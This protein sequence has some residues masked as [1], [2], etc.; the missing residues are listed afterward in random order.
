MKKNNLIKITWLLAIC[1]FILISCGKNEP[2]NTG[3][4]ENKNASGKII[5][6]KASFDFSSTHEKGHP[7]WYAG[8]YTDDNGKSVY[9][10]TEGI[11]C[12]IDNSFK[13][14]NTVEYKKH[15]YN[16]LNEIL[17]EIENKYNTEK[18]AE[19]VKGGNI[20]II[21]NAVEIYLYEESTQFDKI[22][23]ELEEKYSEIIKIEKTDS[24]YTS[25]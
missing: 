10:L 13:E 6:N 3:G 2:I 5:I 8:H 16:K 14:A 15:S 22:K 19:T 7:E 11:E 18:Y 25:W 24:F 20:N 17:H 23:N 9:F 4:N 21:D 1:L 12:E